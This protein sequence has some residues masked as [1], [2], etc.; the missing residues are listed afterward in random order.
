MKVLKFGGTSVGS[1]MMMHRVLDIVRHNQE[2]QV[3]VLSA[4]AGTTNRLKSI[5]ALMQT[6]DRAKALAEFQ[7]LRED[8]VYDTLRLL[9]HR[10]VVKKAMQVINKFFHELTLLVDGPYSDEIEKQMSAYGE[11]IS[12]NLFHYLCEEKGVKSVLLPA[13]DMMR[14]DAAGRP[15]YYFIREQLKQLVLNKKEAVIY[16]TQGYICRN[17][18]GEIDNLG[19]GG[20]DYSATII[21]AM[22]QAEEIQIWTDIDGIHN[23]DPR[24]V[25][26]TTS[27]PHIT[28][29]AAAKL[30]YFGAKI[31]HP[32]CVIPA[33]DQN[34]PVRIKNTFKPD[35]FGT[36][37][38]D[39]YKEEVRQLVS[40]KDNELLLTIHSNNKL[41][42]QE[43]MMKIFE[44]I[45]KNHIEVDM[46][47]V[48]YE[49]ISIVVS[50]DYCIAELVD[51]VKP[52]G[53]VTMEDDFTV[54]NVIG[55]NNLDQVFQSVSGV[56]IRM[57]SQ[58]EDACSYLLM[59]IKSADKVDVL[60]A[61]ASKA[62]EEN[63]F[64]ELAPTV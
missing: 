33:K 55:N 29:E 49:S 50:A 13:L 44:V 40:A 61:L 2:P 31:L 58:K 25:E 60:K 7:K 18:L 28:F 32:L 19:R 15:D 22:L 39:L 46:I 16:I 30:A 37:I 42:G 5:A 36:L 34:I 43:F 21:G 4:M 54:V 48:A 35:A 59:L 51:V 57:T 6:E 63:H 27:I 45:R 62:Y 8:Y 23:N 24:F 11:L 52:Y 1:P 12:T 41:S 20:S 3:L 14:I 53:W 26:G 47:S 38:S 17:H 64:I 56:P 9:R 10:D